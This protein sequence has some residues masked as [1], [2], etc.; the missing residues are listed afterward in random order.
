MLGSSA[1]REKQQASFLYIFG[2]NRLLR[3]SV[4]HYM[5]LFPAIL[6]HDMCHPLISK[7]HIFFCQ[8]TQF[9]I[10]VRKITHVLE[11]RVLHTIYM[12]NNKCIKESELDG[13]SLT[14]ITL[15]ENKVT[16]FA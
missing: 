16:Y 13:E 1:V 12:N 9:S 2:L 10:F 15:Q 3:G 4:A 5:E 8:K 6:A 7:Y 14:T 11:L